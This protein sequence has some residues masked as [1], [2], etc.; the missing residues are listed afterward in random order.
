M[1]S[2]QK[3]IKEAEAPLEEEEPFVNGWFQIAVP[4]NGTQA[5]IKKIVR[6]AGKGKP[7]E[8]KDILK[9]LKQLKVIHG[10]DVNAIEELLKQVDAGEIPDKPVLIALADVKHG[11]NGSI[12]WSIEGVE[13]QEEEIF[14]VPSMQ[15]AV[16]KLTVTGIPGKDVYGK[17]K[18]PRQGFEMQLDVGEGV[19]FTQDKKDPDVI[20]QAAYAGLLKY[21]SNTLSV[22]PC[23]TISEDKLQAHMDIRVGQVSKTGQKLSHEDILKT[24]EAAGIIFGIAEENIKTAIN[25]ADESDLVVKNILVAE[26]KPPVKGEDAIIKWQLDVQAEDSDQRS[27]LPN[28]SIATRIP[29]TEPTAGISIYEEELSGQ[30]GAVN[31]LE[32]GPGVIETEVD[33]HYE[34]RARWL[35]VAEYDSQTITIKSN[36]SVSDDKMTA[37]IDLFPSLAGKEGGEVLWEHI[38][39]S[40]IE[41]DIKYGI[42]DKEIITALEKAKTDHQ[43]HTELLV[44][45]GKA[46]VNGDDGNIEWFLNVNVKEPDQRAVLSKQLLAIRTPPSNQQAGTNVYEEEL[47][48]LDGAG[49]TLE[50][51]Q[52]VIETEV[53]GRFEYRAR[54]LG[55]A[56]LTADSLTV[57]ADANFSDDNMEVTMGL[58]LTAVGKEGG[59]VSL[60]HIQIAL[61][62]LGIKYGIQEKNIISALEEAKAS[63]Q[64]HIKLLVAEGRPP[65]HGI[66]AQLILDRELAAGKLLPNG[67]IDFY[68]RSYPWNVKE[69]DAI[70]R[71]IPAQPEENGINVIG[72]PL[73]AK[74]AEETKLQLEGIEQGV[75]NKLRATQAGVLLVN[76][77]NL[78]VTE[79][80]VI[81]GNVC[82]ETGNIHSDSSVMINGYIE[83]GFTLEAMG[84]VVIQDNVE[85]ATVRSDGSV[86]IKSGIRGTHTEIISKG[87]ITTSF[88]ENAKLKTDTDIIVKNSIIGCDASCQ[89]KISVGD[90]HSKKSSL[91]GGITRGSKGIEAAVLGTDSY[92]KTFIEAGLGPDFM[93]HFKQLAVELETKKTSLEDL[94]KV[95]E[96]YQKQSSPQQEELLQKVA[97]T[98]KTMKQEYDDV[99]FEHDA[100]EGQLE[101]SKK[102]TVVVHRHVYP[103]VWIHILDKIYEVTEERN[104]GVFRLDGKHIIFEPT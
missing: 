82:Q 81:N 70:G 32:C 88:A 36:I 37:T 67:K 75:D 73:S 59:D 19:C 87:S 80:L 89:G 100:L 49:S 60:E 23:L 7:I 15:I 103:G 20:Y 94:Q 46:P 48:G 16:R 101:E 41:Q 30:A 99:L 11:E 13:D 45:R 53:D 96:H 72:E 64:P 14:V 83:P 104:A 85:D 97:N 79:T 35:G 74:P 57:T 47:P 78:K 54:W 22:D 8:V 69:K 84:D 26:G 40:L 51:D 61:L 68:E 39:T 2:P 58:F 102:A 93:K 31:A 76:G 63:H 42:Q 44:A 10:I 9:K 50:S 66:N 98:L 4:S 17:K 33:G 12:E 24:L 1:S 3:V 91:I 21:E 52:G 25:N 38:L 27:V 55:V 71:I 34:Y 18:Q 62:E 56:Q 29:P 28:Q 65:K 92:Q 5:C 95:S 43:P 90:A 86:L 6:H 77:L